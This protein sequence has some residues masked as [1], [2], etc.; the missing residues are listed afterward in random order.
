MEEPKPLVKHDARAE[1]RSVVD[2]GGLRR[3]DLIS[4][5]DG[6]RNFELRKYVVEPDVEVG[7]HRN[8]VEHEQYVL[9]GTYTIGID[10]EEFQVS[11]GHSV[12]IPSETIHWYR[13]ETD[14][15]ATYLC[16]VPIGDEGTEFIE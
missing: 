15:P 12:F 3:A 10:E 11:A 14:A 8:A 2:T 5:A 9:E 6:A 7:K 16:I 13:N 1:Y 4:A